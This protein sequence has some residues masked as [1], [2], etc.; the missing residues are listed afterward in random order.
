[1]SE[2]REI[3]DKRLAKGEISPEEH[4]EVIAAL[5]GGDP[6]KNK[7][8]NHAGNS[9]YILYAA[10]AIFGA[11]A[12]VFL[13]NYVFAYF[14]CTG[15]KLSDSCITYYFTES[16]ENRAVRQTPEQARKV[17]LFIGS[18][19]AVVASLLVFVSRKFLGRN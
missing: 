15:W 9:K 10:A 16:A 19:G 2:A 8:E 14:A 18:L 5:D 1:M 12:A 7:V 11:F 6:V 17:I 13:F 3:V 4:A